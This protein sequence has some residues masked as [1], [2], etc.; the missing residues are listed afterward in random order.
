MQKV[1]LT[2][3]EYILDSYMPMSLLGNDWSSVTNALLDDAVSF[4]VLRELMEE[5]E[6]DSLFRNPVAVS[7]PIGET[8][9]A[10][11]SNGV[12]RVVAAKL[13]GAERLLVQ[14]GYVQSNP[15]LTYSATV[16]EVALAPVE[17]RRGIQQAESMPLLHLLRSLKVHSQLWVAAD[18]A[19]TVGSSW[20]FYWEELVAGDERKVTQAVRR[21]LAMH[22]PGV[23]FRVHTRLEEWGRPAGDP[24]EEAL[25]ASIGD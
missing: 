20:V 19:L 18:M 23:A 9:P 4:G 25:W 5:L 17:L 24:D 15:A 11:V 13:S 6:R 3:V 7:V 1:Y 21:K 2:P 8:V 12:R 22:Y 16:T 10:L 14:E